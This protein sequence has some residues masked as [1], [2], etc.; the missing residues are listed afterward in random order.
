MRTPFKPLAVVT[1]AAIAVSLFV[2]F[3]WA[4]ERESRYQPRRAVAADEAHWSTDGVTFRVEGTQ[5]AV[6]LAGNEATLGVPVALRD[7]ISYR[8]VLSDDEQLLSLVTERGMAV[9]EAAAPYQQRH[10]WP[11]NDEPLAGR[12]TGG[13]RTEGTIHYDLH[14]LDVA[15]T[16][17]PEGSRVCIHTTHQNAS[18]FDDVQNGIVILRDVASGDEIRRFEHVDWGR[19]V[20]KVVWSPDGTRLATFSS[21]NRL[22][23]MI[24]VWDVATGEQVTEIQG[25]FEQFRFS[26][27]ASKLI[28]LTEFYPEVLQVFDADDGELVSSRQQAN[29][30]SFHVSPDGNSIAVVRAPSG[31]FAGNRD[32]IEL[33]DAATLEPRWTASVPGAAGLI[34]FRPDNGEIAATWYIPN[35]FFGSEGGVMAFD[36]ADG[37]VVLDDRELLYPGGLYYHADG[38]LQ[39]GEFVYELNQSE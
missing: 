2:T 1:T 26:E 33:L 17:S 27:D 32:R 9:W 21:Y 23:Y 37:D 12:A 11:A 7:S 16:L 19:V 28:T 34:V 29:M 6:N 3:I 35:E 10:L 14:E 24:R 31:L 25:I 36:A 15:F 38:S 20:D 5:L 4:D 30:R 13:T 39:A 8:V 18:Q 22:G